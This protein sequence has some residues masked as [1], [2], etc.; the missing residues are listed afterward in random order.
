MSKEKVLKVIA[1]ATRK[2]AS[3]ASSSASMYYIFQPETPKK[4]KKKD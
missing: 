2:V 3:Q 1:N 4:L